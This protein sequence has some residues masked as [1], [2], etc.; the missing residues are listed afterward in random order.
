M[1]STSVSKE[2][3]RSQS[4]IHSDNTPS[5]PPSLQ[6]VTS[7]AQGTPSFVSATDADVYFSKFSES[8]VSVAPAIPTEDI[9]LNF[10]NNHMAAIPVDDKATELLKLALP[11]LPDVD[12][13]FPHASRGILERLSSDVVEVASRNV[14][15]SACLKRYETELEYYSGLQ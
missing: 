5:R 11:C 15:W 12:P 8:P 6:A 2:Q 9:D 3:S 10:V 7:P 13:T 14:A 4:P 1:P